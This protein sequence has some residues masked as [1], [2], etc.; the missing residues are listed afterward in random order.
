MNVSTDPL[1]LVFLYR[2]DLFEQTG[3]VCVRFTHLRRPFLNLYLKLIMC[4][5]KLGLGFA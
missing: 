4:F 1:P 3:K 2:D 5:S